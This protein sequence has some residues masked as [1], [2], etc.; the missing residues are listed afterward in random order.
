MQCL[1]VMSLTVHLLHVWV[2]L[3][4]CSAFESWICIE[5]CVSFHDDKT[6]L[7]RFLDHTIGNSFYHWVKLSL[8]KTQNLYS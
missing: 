5:Q 1:Y 7:L 3:P 8:R 2:A 4:K 6:I